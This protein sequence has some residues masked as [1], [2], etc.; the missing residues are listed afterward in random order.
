MA[1]TPSSQSSSATTGEDEGGGF[2]EVQATTGTGGPPAQ[3]RSTPSAPE[4]DDYFSKV[5]KYIPAEIVAGFVTLNGILLGDATIP[6]TVYWLVFVGLLALTPIY[7]WRV[8]R[9]ANFPVAYS[10]IIV[11]TVSFAI[12]VFAL[13]GPF[14]FFS[15]YKAVYGSILLIMYTLF[16]PL[17]VGK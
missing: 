14:S 6:Q 13:G 7:T 3:P 11:A 5:V 2:F 4:P 8:T 10:Q 15:W 16:V 9:A 1:R 12:W 17:V